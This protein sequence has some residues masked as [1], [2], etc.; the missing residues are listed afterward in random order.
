MLNRDDPKSKEDGSSS[1]GGDE[2]AVVEANPSGIE[3]SVA[4]GTDESPRD[5]DES[6]ENASG[7]EEEEE[8]SKKDEGEESREV[9]EG[10][11][12]KEAVDEGEKVKEAGDD[13]TALA[14]VVRAHGTESHAGLV[15]DD[16]HEGMQPLKFHFP[17][18]QYQKS[19]KLSGK[20]YLDTCL[21]NIQAI[22]KEK[23]RAWF[24]EHPQFQHFF[25]IK[26]RK[27]KWMGLWIIVLR[28]ACVAKKYELWFIVNGVPIRYS[29]RELGLISGLYCHEYPPNHERLGGTAFMNK[30]FG[31]KRVTY[32]DVEKQMLSMKSKPSEDRKK[33]AVLY[34]LASI[35]VGG[36]K[37]GDAASRVDSFFLNDVDDLAACLTFPWGR[38]AFEH[39]LKD[40]SSFLEKSN[41]VAPT[42]WVFTSFPIPLELLA[43]EAIPSLRNHYRE[44]VIG[45]R[46]HCPRMCKMEY[47]RK[48]G[49]K[50]FSLN[51]MNDKLGTDTK[52]IESILVAKTA[53]KELLQAIGMDKERCWADDS[54]D[55]AVDSWSKILEKG[56]TQVFFEERFRIDC[57]ARIAKLNGP[58]NPIGGPSNNA[59]S[60]AHEDSVEDTGHEA[61][62]AMDGRLMKAVKDAVKVAVKDAVK[63]LN[64]TVSSLSDKV[65]LLEDEVKS[66]RPSGE[67]QSEEN[68][69]SDEEDD[70]DKASEE[71]DGGDKETKES[72][73]ED[74]VN[75]YIRD[76]TNEVQDE[77]GTM[78]EDDAQMIAEAEKAE[79]EK[80]KKK[81]KR[82]RIDD[83]KEAEPS[84]KAKGLG[85][86]RTPVFTRS[87]VA[88]KGA[89]KAA[90][91][92]KEA[93]AAKK[94]AG[95][96][97]AAQ[98]KPSQK[99]K[100]KTMKVGKK[101]E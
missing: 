14:L 51:A 75:N 90:A 81:K 96:K 68:K 92:E 18:S 88:K 40:V 62:K 1:V 49:T 79:A 37:T 10:E 47:K 85:K 50:A 7:K 73:E 74:D 33:M 31:G 30:Y 39:N 66:L 100:E 63:E 43:F 4:P 58:T 70:V 21:S 48:S 83:R 91:A 44:N 27:Q 56:S 45:A 87:K 24:I 25:H 95:E 80:A 99:P 32:A 11:K 97:K 57:E 71:E 53:E 77:H 61:L 41:G 54:D 76:V 60:E 20:C 2:T 12:E 86:A 101:T 78:D 65:T 55:A 36:R 93:A 34:L 52:D 38:Y 8:S 72:E 28:S 5:R 84:K 82:V 67:N 16:K 29:L 59:Q 35:L 6:E 9:N 89:K 15:G 19:L 17:P 26:N 42:S 46:P 94:A 98:K 13:E 69:E 3:K 22:L 64:K 23:E